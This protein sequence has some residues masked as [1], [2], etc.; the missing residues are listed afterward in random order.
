VAL[1]DLQKLDNDLGGRPDHDLPL[2]GLLGIVDRVEGIVQNRSADHLGGC[3]VVGTEIL[4]S[5]EEMRYL[6]ACRSVPR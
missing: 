5:S 6:P 3:R 4:K 2:A 1:H